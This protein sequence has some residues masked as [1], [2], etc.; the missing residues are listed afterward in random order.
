[1]GNISTGAQSASIAIIKERGCIRINTLISERQEKKKEE[2]K[3]ERKKMKLN[4]E[5][6]EIEQETE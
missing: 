6:Q 5:E 1:M 4:F 2:K 3:K